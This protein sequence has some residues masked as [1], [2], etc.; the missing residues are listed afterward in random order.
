MIRDRIA[1]QAKSKD[2]EVFLI[3]KEMLSEKYNRNF[4]ILKGEKTT[5]LKTAVEHIDKL[6]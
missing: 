2:E 3:V 1:G 5:R 4:V 6:L